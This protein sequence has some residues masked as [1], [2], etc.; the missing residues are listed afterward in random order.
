MSVTFVLVPGKMMGKRKSRDREWKRNS[1]LLVIGKDVELHIE[2]E[3]AMPGGIRREIFSRYLSVTEYLCI[4]QH[5]K[6]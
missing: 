1:Q 4:F 2:L 6:S 3:F 5:N